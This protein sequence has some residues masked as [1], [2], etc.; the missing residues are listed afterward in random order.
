M[1]KIL[2]IEDEAIL[3]DEIVEWLTFEDYTVFSATDGVEGV[4]TAFRVLPDLIIC[5]IT[6]PRL[7]GYGVLLEMRSHP[8]TISTPFIFVTARAAVEDM[9]QGM[10]LGADDYITK[11]FTRLELLRAVQ[12]RLEKKS[13]QEQAYHEAVGQWRQAFEQE[14]EQ[15]L[16]KAK[17]VAM[18]S[19]DFRNPL[20]SILSS[21]SILRDYANR[22]D[23]H[24]RLGYFNRIEASVRQLIQMLD[25]MLVVSQMETGNIEFTPEVLNVGPFFQ[26]IVDEFQSIHEETH[27][28][29]F[30][31][32]FTG[33]IMADPRLLRQIIANLISNAIKYS[34]SGT[35]V[36]VKL[37]SVDSQ[38]IL[39]V[40]DHGIGI[41]E[42][43][44]AHIFDSFQRGS[45]VENV[46]GT[47]LGLAIV[48]QAAEFHNA[49]IS[50]ESEVG[51]GTTFT[52]V[53]PMA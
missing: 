36:R 38:C 39:S 2:V 9:R 24:R 32:H 7:D 44:Q 30:D 53:I 10:D 8:A 25:D 3:R 46:S 45:N 17:L 43:D 50:L 12:T 37:D 47:G 1:P 4:E 31:N 40:Q 5:D 52:V 49:A 41:P 29:A 20:A 19:H 15:R 23:E 48:R 22:M 28:I 26:Q 13:L 27:L 6:M 35:E 21:T 34:H 18:F 51:I 11:P 33:T 14:R 42:A 16:F